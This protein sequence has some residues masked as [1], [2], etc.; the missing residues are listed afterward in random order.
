MDIVREWTDVR[1]Y[2]GK[3]EISN[4]GIVWSHYRNR[5]LKGK[6]DKDGYHTVTLRQNG[7]NKSERVHRLVALH[8]CEKPEGCNIV[9]H[10]D[11]NVLNNHYTN[12]EWTTIKGNTQ[13]AYDNSSSFRDNVRLMTEKA[14]IVNSMVIDVYKG[15]EYVGR[16]M[17]KENCAA[18]LGISPKTIYNHINRDTVTRHGYRFE[19]VVNPREY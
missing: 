17:G 4:D 2:N 7:K 18:E 15:D 9:N 12:L 19:E 16:F 6:L 11:M 13:H 1:G 3:Y 5:A 8:Y 10:L 14:R